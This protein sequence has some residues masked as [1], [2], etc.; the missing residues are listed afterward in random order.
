MAIADY[1]LIALICLY[2][3]LIFKET[4]LLTS[5]VYSCWRDALRIF[6]FSVRASKKPSRKLARKVAP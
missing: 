3:A 1:V 2:C 6:I 5:R 4:R